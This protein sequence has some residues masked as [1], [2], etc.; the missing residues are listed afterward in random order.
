VTMIVD[1][2]VGNTRAKWRL[3]ENN[4]TIQNGSIA[5]S[6]EDWSALIALSSHKPVRM[7]ASN[8]AGSMVAKRLQTIANK[9]LGVEVEFAVACASSGEVKSGYQRPEQ[10][11]VDRWLAIVAAWSLFRRGCVVIDAGSALTVDFIDD[12]ALHLGGY[13]VPGQ[14]MMLASLFGGTSGVRI[15]PVQTQCIAYGVNTDL[16]VQNG[17]FAMTLALIQAAV[18]QDD[19]GGGTAS[20]V[21]TGGDAESLL[22]HLPEGVVHRPDLVLDGL[23]LALP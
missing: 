10:L 2:D 12:R 16:A 18:A 21:L 15:N 20:M 19:S 17:C 6:S 11:G 4:V 1:I 14:Q 8:V 9:Y 13:I 23:A 7:R 22:P 3:S 5:T